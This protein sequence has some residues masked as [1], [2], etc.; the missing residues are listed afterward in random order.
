MILLITVDYREMT[1]LPAFGSCSFGSFAAWL[2]DLGFS[3]VIM[4]VMELYISSGFCPIDTA[5]FSA[6]YR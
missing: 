4:R 2:A 3:Q 1:P 5:I 6:R